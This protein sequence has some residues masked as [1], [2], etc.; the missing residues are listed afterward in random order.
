VIALRGDEE[1]AHTRSF[2]F[3]GTIK[4]HLLVLK[5]LRRLGLL[6]LRPFRDEVCEDLGLDGLSWTELKLELT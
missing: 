1:Y 4:V 5:L 6:G 3:Q 2:A